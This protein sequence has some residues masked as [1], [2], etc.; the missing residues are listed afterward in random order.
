MKYKDVVVLVFLSAVLVYAVCSRYNLTGKGF[1]ENHCNTKACLTTWSESVFH[2]D[3]EIKADTVNGLTVR[4]TGG[5]TIA[6]W[7]HIKSGSIILHRNLNWDGD[8]VDILF[9]R[10]SDT[11]S[12]PCF[13]IREDGSIETF[14]I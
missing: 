1:S 5:E 2:R 7:P 12:I 4:R 14:D 6:E 8:T 3:I 9:S 11:D 13:L 10:F